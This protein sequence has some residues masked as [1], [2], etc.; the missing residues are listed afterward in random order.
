M[1]M[2]FQR[3]PI[4]Y[5]A[6]KDGKIEFKNLMLLQR[7]LNDRGKIISRRVS[8]VSA[9]EQRAITEA[10]KHAR[11]MALLPTGGVRK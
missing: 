5:Q 2:R 11:F 4:T 8:G 9:K 1:P 3:A 7:Y 6:A 10:I